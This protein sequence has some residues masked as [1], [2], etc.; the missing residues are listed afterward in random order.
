MHCCPSVPRRRPNSSDPVQRQS[1]SLT[2]RA[3]GAGESLC[4]NPPAQELLTAWVPYGTSAGA[5][6]T[7]A[8]AELSWRLQLRHHLVVVGPDSTPRPYTVDRGPIPPCSS[9]LP[10]QRSCRTT[11]AVPCGL[12]VVLAVPFVPPTGNCLGRNHGRGR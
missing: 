10:M 12:L 3:L 1:A 8:S 4:P 11:F 7:G 6:P 9:P 5:D 2:S